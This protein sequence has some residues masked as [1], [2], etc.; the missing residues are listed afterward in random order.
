MP[1]PTT[2]ARPTGKRSGFTLPSDVSDLTGAQKAATLLI[3]LGVET[4]GEVLRKMDDADVEQVSIEIAQLRNVSSNLVEGVL[5]EYRDMAMARDYIGQGGVPYARDVLQKALGPRRADEI[6][7]RVEAA[8]EVSAFHLLQTVETSQLTTFLQNEHPQTAALILAHLNP[9]KAAD[10][11]A[12]LPSDLQNEIMYRLATM[13]KT[14]PEMLNDIEDVI[15]NQIGS[16]IGAELSVTGGIGQVAEILNATSRS[17]ERSILD[18][19]RKRSDE[20]ATNIKGLM[21]VFDDLSGVSAPDLQR[22]LMDVD[23]RDLALSLKAVSDE[24]KE[25]ILRN[26][27]ERVA[28]ALNEE[29]ELLGRVRVSDVDEAQ[30][31]ILEVAQQLEANEEIVLSRS[32]EDA[33]I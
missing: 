19:I 20:L 9:R 29:I 10:I 18:D 28:V 6:M 33:M 23:Q 24:L 30:Q 12:S 13:G 11:V 16:L 5:L 32:A 7:M 4:A 14:S 25:K 8:M 2:N 17:A 27:S 26:V 3:A 15:R 1:L 21:F 22:L 31:R